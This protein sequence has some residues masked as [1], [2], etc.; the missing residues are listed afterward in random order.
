M[1]GLR[2]VLEVLRVEVAATQDD[3][4]LGTA[5]HEE[6]P[7]VQEAQVPG[8]HPTL[9]ISF[10]PG[11]EDL[12]RLFGTPPITTGHGRPTDPDFPHLA[13]FSEAPRG[14]FDD[15]DLVSID[16]KAAR[17]QA[18]AAQPPC[19]ASLFEGLGV[20]TVD[21]RCLPRLATADHQRRF[22]QAIAGKKSVLAEAG[23]GEALR[24]PLQGLGPH[25]LGAVEGDDPP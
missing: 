2:H 8:S 4:V 9:V 23:R 11:V 17:H 13:G 12:P 5:G 6:L 7:A 1:G 3:Q 21:K 22:G 10:E 18:P 25:R 20:I 19:A 14:S 24:E 16:G 15:N